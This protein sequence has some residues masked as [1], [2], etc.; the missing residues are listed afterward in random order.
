MNAQI[1]LFLYEPKQFV[2]F[3]TW[4]IFQEPRTWAS[5]VAAS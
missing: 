5:I 1:I 4:L 3:L 2:F